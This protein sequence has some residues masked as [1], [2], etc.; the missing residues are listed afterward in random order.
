VT[1][2]TGSSR[3]VSGTFAPIGPTPSPL[4][5]S[6]GSD[7]ER[8]NFSSQSFSSQHQPRKNPYWE[9]S[10]AF[11]T[12]SRNSSAGQQPQQPQQQQPSLTSSSASASSISTIIPPL[13]Y[14]QG[15]TQ[16]PASYANPAPSPRGRKERMKER[17][18][19]ERVC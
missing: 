18:M 1:C 5:L 11:I 9:R 14:H 8:S 10:D 16:Q 4:T 3:P 2:L 17:K 12:S 15:Y 19:K 7:S 6:G 13:S